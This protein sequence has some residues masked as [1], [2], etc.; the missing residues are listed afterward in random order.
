MLAHNL[1]YS[2]YL[3]GLIARISAPSLS[4]LRAYLFNQLSFTIPR[5]VQF[6]KSC[7]SLRFSATKV[8]FDKNLVQLDMD[9]RNGV[10]LMELCVKCRHLNWQVASA[11][12]VLGTLSP[13]LSVIENVTL[14]T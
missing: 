5:I 6:M 3:D 10:P 11:V 12:Q 7:E 1:P 9:T 13:L 14:S 2:A 8:A 4:V